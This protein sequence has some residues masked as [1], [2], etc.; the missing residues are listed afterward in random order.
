MVS[1]NPFPLSKRVKFVLA[2]I[3]S[4]VAFIGWVWI[5]L[6]FL[7]TEFWRG[8][9]LVGTVV[10]LAG[11]GNGALIYYVVHQPRGKLILMVSETLDKI[12]LAHA[13]EP[14]IKNATFDGGRPKVKQL[15]GAVDESEIMVVD[16]WNLQDAEDLYLSST[17]E[18]TADPDEYLASKA[19]I[20]ENYNDLTED[21]QESIV[22][23][24]LF[25]TVVRRA[26]ERINNE[27]YS[28]LEKG[29]HPDGEAIQEEINHVLR[30]HGLL[31]D[32]SE[33]DRVSVEEIR[34]EVTDEV[35]NGGVAHE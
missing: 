29:E 30:Q 20:D 27:I 24:A 14:A 8:T 28:K 16:D 6:E 25:S 26:V 3:G 2:G 32:G 15:V 23:R 9:W 7:E 18:K 22:Q 34:E 1:L 21:A 10:I 5:Y 11:I 33:E 19:K 4:V 13:N 31:E 12:G 35:L 17:W